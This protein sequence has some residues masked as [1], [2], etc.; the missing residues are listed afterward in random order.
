MPASIDDLF[1]RFAASGDPRPLGEVFDRCSGELLSLALHLCSEPADAEDALQATFVTAIEKRAEWDAARPLQPWLGGILVLHCKKLRE[2]RARRREA[3]L[4]ELVGEDGSVVA[5]SERRELIER[6]RTH[7]QAL[8][9]EQRA[10]VLLQLEH[11]LQPSQIAEVL[12]VPPGTVR[13]RLWRGLR[14]LRSMLPAGLAALLGAL[15][16]ARGVAAVRQ[17]VVRHAAK[18]AAVAGGGGLLLTKLFAGAAAVLLLLVA[19]IVW[20]APAAPLGATAPAQVPAPAAAVGTGAAAV[21]VPIERT[22]LVTPAAAAAARLLVRLVWDR[23][24]TPLPNVPLQLL[25]V[26]SDCDPTF[27]A[28]DGITGLDGICAL[29]VSAAGTFCI[30]AIGGLRQVVELQRGTTASAELRMPAAEPP[31]QRLR[32]CVVLADGAPAPGA[33]IVLSRSGGDEVMVAGVADAAGR[34]ELAAVAAWVLVGAR[35]PGQ[36]PS[37][38][39]GCAPPR[40]IELVLPGAG[41]GL[42]GI[43]VD[44]AGRPVRGAPVLCGCVRAERQRFDPRGYLSEPRAAGWLRTDEQ[45]RFAAA[46]LPAGE[47]SLLVRADGHAPLQRYVDTKAGEVV[48]VRCEL[49]TGCAVHGVVVDGDGLPVV[50]ARVF[51]GGSYCE[52]RRTDAAGRFGFRAAAATLQPLRV[53]AVDTA[54]CNTERDLGA[55]PGEW[56]VVVQRL[57]RYRLRFVDEQGAPLAGWTVVVRA[58]AFEPFATDADGR[59]RV[60]APAD[61][62]GP[63]AVAPPDNARA[64]VPCAWPA[65]IGPGIESTIVVPAA[66]LPSA[67]IAGSV[68]DVDGAALVVGRLAVLRADGSYVSWHGIDAGAFATG[69]LPPGDYVLEV[70]RQGRGAAGARFA[71]DDLHRGERRDVGTL[72]L[73]AEGQLLLHLVRSDGTEPRAASV[74]LYSGDHVEHFAPPADGAPHPWPQ[75]RYEWLV[76]DDDSLWQRG[77]V[78]VHAGELASVG[79]VLQPAVRRYLQFPV[80]TPD[81]GK[82]ARVDYLLRAPDG[83]V[84]DRG[85]FDPRAELPYRY[86][87]PLSVGRWTLELATDGGQR[88]AGGFEVASMEP[89]KVPIRVAVQPAR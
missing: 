38:L 10:V 44:A 26:R 81:W 4:G 57:P 54:P 25:P 3:E 43:V 66:A 76:M 49:G 51:L 77:T 1:R 56:R 20:P 58:S 84:Y 55:E 33:E 23:D 14:T 9:E 22:A 83:S 71:V 37:L 82:P 35:L 45:G 42:E 21:P 24:G 32:G 50:G 73:P 18:V 39:Q 31:V 89:S 12:S 48:H 64:A 65:G 7:V 63:L 13:M 70:H 86:C 15:L 60:P 72:R 53:E 61:D 46:D 47:L 8:P 34:F 67:V 78:E 85:D 19:W 69:E 2:R 29:R 79:I 30:E 74:F 40:D 11:G 68:R 41:A 17:V 80:P 87:P 36:A 27:D 75:G 16:P 6:L 59:C 62:L 5:A 52:L 28:I 88:F